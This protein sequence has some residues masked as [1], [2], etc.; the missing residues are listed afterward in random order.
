[1]INK[2]FLKKSFWKKKFKKNNM[3]F[4]NSLFQSFH[5]FFTLQH[6]WK[7]L[8]ENLD[9]DSFC[10][11]YF[12]SR[13]IRNVLESFLHSKI[14]SKFDL[15]FT[16]EN[17][18]CHYYQWLLAKICIKR[19]LWSNSIFMQIFNDNKT[20][21]ESRIVH[22]FQH[23]DT[24]SPSIRKNFLNVFKYYWFWNSHDKNEWNNFHAKIKKGI[25]G[26]LMPHPVAVKEMM[27]IV[28][29][30]PLK[31]SGS[32]LKMVDKKKKKKNRKSK[33]FY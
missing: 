11:L 7:T 15:R 4:S 28:D 21:I 20:F 26:Y 16:L 30:L 10:C 18:K 24:W 23:V 3:Q 9:V 13:I 33:Q 8:I 19:N 14:I 25:Y 29:K 2:K 22:D 1:M 12:T 32:K 5:D 31:N 6:L 27:K 17:D